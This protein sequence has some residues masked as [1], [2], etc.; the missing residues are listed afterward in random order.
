MFR[1][2]SKKYPDVITGGGGFGPV[3]ENGYGVS[4]IIGGEDVIF[5]HITSKHLSSD[6][7]SISKKLFVFM[8]IF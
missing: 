2:N 4:Y 1:M 6:T 5:F 8:Y 3:D 7:V